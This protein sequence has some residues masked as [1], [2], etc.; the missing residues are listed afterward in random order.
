MSREFWI[1]ATPW[2]LDCH[3]FHVYEVDP[4]LENQIKL[5]EVNPDLDAAVEGLVEALYRAQHEIDKMTNGFVTDHYRREKA[6]ESFHKTRE[7]LANWERV[8][9]ER[10]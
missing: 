2:S 4:K 9:G 7:A 1:A 6:M 10:K 5:R 3:A 8:K